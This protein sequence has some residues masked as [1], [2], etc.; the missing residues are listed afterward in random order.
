MMEQPPQ[1]GPFGDVPDEPQYQFLREYW[2]RECLGA[3]YPAPGEDRKQRVYV[4]HRPGCPVSQRGPA[5]QEPGIQ[6]EPEW[7]EPGTVRNI[8]RPFG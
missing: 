6:R 8:V 2:C 1:P 3:A 5:R 7:N 4:N